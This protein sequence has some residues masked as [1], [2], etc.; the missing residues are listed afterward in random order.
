MF[1]PCFICIHMSLVESEIASDKTI[2]RK[3]ECGSKKTAG[4]HSVPNS[5]GWESS[6]LKLIDAFI[7]V[8]T[9]DKTITKCSRHS[10]WMFHSASQFSVE[11]FCELNI[12]QKV[13]CCS[14]YFSRICHKKIISVVLQF[15]RIQYCVLGR[16]Y[17]A[18]V[19]SLLVSIRANTFTILER[20]D[21]PQ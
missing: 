16:K 14:I 6:H 13:K 20:R 5:N 2:E 12:K 18:K 7:Y 1:S 4:S 21:L 10:S 3:I 15:S 11:S 19:D 9:V 17:S 8:Y